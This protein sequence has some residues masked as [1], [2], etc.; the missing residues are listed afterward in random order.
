MKTDEQ[1]KRER[2][3]QNVEVIIRVE[4]VTKTYGT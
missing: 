2:F 1:G 4:R 3:C